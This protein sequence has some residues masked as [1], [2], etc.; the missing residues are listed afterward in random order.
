M[1]PIYLGRCV[2]EQRRWLPHIPPV[3]FEG[4]SHYPLRAVGATFAELGAVVA[5]YR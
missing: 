5:S 2:G 4:A 3:Q 1:V